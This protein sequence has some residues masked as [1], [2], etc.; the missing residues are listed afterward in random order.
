LLPS[1]HVGRRLAVWLVFALAYALA[2]ETLVHF[3]ALPKW[4]AGNE[5]VAALTVGLGVL[6]V[7]RN[8]VAYS[9]WWEARTLWGQLINELR[10]L[11]LKVRAHV[12]ADPEEFRPF[13]RLLI[14]FAHALRLHLRSVKGVQSV[15]G[16][17]H[18]PTTFPHAP[19][20][21]AER[22]HQTLDRWNRQG[23]LEGTIWILDPHAAALMD[24]CGACER[25]RNT[26]LAPSYRA[27]WRWGIAL[28]VVVAPWPAA[29]D[30]G[31]WCLSVLAVAFAFLIGI[32]LTAEAVEEP[33]GQEGDDLSLETY[34]RSIE[35]F[36]TAALEGPSTDPAREDAL[37]KQRG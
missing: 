11:A 10:N 4:V 2:V 13:A 30:M 21:I 26:P 20:Y 24:V 12:A 23:K 27:L 18:E 16:F 17:E 29:M 36:V 33:F 14:G 15:P 5:V 9:R 3:L 31:W 32:E 22:V 25:I 6:V 8:N 1:S 28:F 35:T 34:C 37:T 7:F 19:G